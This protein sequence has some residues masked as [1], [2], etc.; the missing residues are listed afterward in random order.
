MLQVTPR[1]IEYLQG[2]AGVRFTQFVDDLIRTEARYRQVDPEGVVLTNYKTTQP[3]GGVDAQVERAIADAP[4]WLTAKTVWQYKATRDM[5]TVDSL[6]E[7]EYIRNMVVEGYA[8]R[9]AYAGSIP[10]E[11]KRAFEDAVNVR[12]RELRPDGPFAFLLTADDLADWANA[13][14]GFV[15]THF[16]TGL[17]EHIQH[18]D[19]WTRNART[20]T[21]QYVPIPGW[22][23]VELRLLQHLDFTRHCDEAVFLIRG[24]SGVGKTRFVCEAVGRLPGVGGILLY[25]DSEQVPIARRLANDGRFCA[26]LIAD[27]CDIECR[28]WLEE[29]LRGHKDR[30]RVVAITNDFD[31]VAGPE[32]DIRLG[33]MGRV[34]LEAMIEANYSGVDPVRRRA[35]AELADGFPRFAADL[36]RHDAEIQE[37]GTPG[38]AMR[39]IGEYLELRFRNDPAALTAVQLLSLFTK[40][41]FKLGLEGELE[42]ACEMLH[43][44]ASAV[45]NALSNS[46]KAGFVAVGG[47]FF[48]VTPRVVGDVLFA[49]AWRRWASDDPAAFLAG[50]P[51]L[52]QR[53]FLDRVALSGREDIRRVCGDY[54]RHWAGNLT[55]AAL[56][57]QET[58]ERLAALVEAHPD[59]YLPEL[60]RALEA[61]TAE[62]L[63]EIIG[64]WTGPGWG[65]RRILVWLAERFAQ[66]GE[67]YQ[68]SERVLFLLAFAEN[69]NEIANNATGIWVQLHRIVLSGTAVPYPER[70]AEVA[71][72]LERPA[73]DSREHSL[74]I[75]ALN[76]AFDE[77]PSRTL[78]PVVVAGRIAPREWSPRTN[79]EYSE[80]YTATF[81][82]FR[83]A[84]DWVSTAARGEL[85]EVL[86]RHVRSFL[87]HGFVADASAVARSVELS[88]AH[89]HRL[90]DAVDIFLDFDVGKA[91]GAKEYDAEYVAGVEEWRREIV[92]VGLHARLTYAVGSSPWAPWK[93]G[94]EEEWKAEMR[95]LAE[96]LLEDDARALRSEIAWLWSA[97][98]A[99]AGEFGDVVGR[100]DIE[101]K[102]RDI[103]L[104]RCRDVGTSAFAKGYTFG[105]THASA[106][107][108]AEFNRWLDASE[109]KWPDVVCDLAQANEPSLHGVER[110]LR[111]FDRGVLP[112]RYLNVPW[113]LRG[114]A[115]ARLDDVD[116]VLARLAEAV[117]A[118]QPDATRIAESSLSLLLTRS[119]ELIGRSAVRE[120]AWRMV[121]NGNETEM[122][123]LHSLPDIVVALADFDAERAI[124]VAARW[125]FDDPSRTFR[126]DGR[127]V[128]VRLAGKWYS[129]MLRVLSEYIFDS[130]RRWH[131]F[132]GDY[133]A[134]V[135]S[136]PSE[137]VADWVAENGV[138][139]ARAIARHLP[140]LSIRD[141]RGHV[142]ELT[143]WILKEYEA[144]DQVFQ[145]FAA[146]VHGISAH[147]GNISDHLEADARFAEAFLGH[148]LRRVREWA[149]REVASARANA[150]AWRIREEE[151]GLRQ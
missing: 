136:M 79:V 104:E 93:R 130:Q 7:G 98:V 144:D 113:L 133:R 105:A 31:R 15:L 132:V 115:L 124:R 60:R 117:G 77:T 118:A 110:V 30:V 61:A 14:L 114:T 41:G 108:V 52:L 141:G 51:E 139:A 111:L 122:L 70:L 87:R 9:V 59:T 45:R 62:E 27:E 54:F 73:A 43:V 86:L 53:R 131:F 99:S 137:D 97:D 6:F 11:R 92:G 38:V 12:C 106:N 50:I 107:A 140:S 35:Y 88:E 44:E 83:R 37:V 25:V 125:E 89:R 17:D 78:P 150:A 116:R 64:R 85:V 138:E 128:L 69:E 112:A 66:F 49:S 1:E 47:R 74:A 100:A 48:Y 65:P 103:V 57:S 126:D 102:G 94:A 24:E 19:S 55:A 63:T 96:A 129:V 21:P 33:R 32:P 76:E 146:G 67:F 142:P 2:E 8:I 20:L 10:A 90:L 91:E 145:E 80:C 28:Y 29:T 3:D 148:E 143:G 127:Q 16:R 119:K 81:Q 13:F 58:A 68:D 5:P 56:Q 36:C 71:A 26:I 18:M 101:G 39:N 135:M 123:G 109:S 120:L 23:D 4:E 82:L 22:D 84:F 75:R 46:H 42:A 121:E 151:E 134:V 40:I 95:S 147:V 72:L 34:E 149:A